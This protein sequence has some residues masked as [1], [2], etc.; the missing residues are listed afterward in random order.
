MKKK[1][2]ERFYLEDG[3]DLK[4]GLKHTKSAELSRW[5]LITEMTMRELSWIEH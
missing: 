4:Y 2:R 5:S 1:F 3:M